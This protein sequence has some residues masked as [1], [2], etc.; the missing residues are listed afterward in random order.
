MNLVE[1]NYKYCS[2]AEL[3]NDFFWGVTNL[4]ASTSI[5]GYYRKYQ[6]ALEFKCFTNA[7]KHYHRH[8]KKATKF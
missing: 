1:Y 7:H 8:R 5:K 4:V 2:M 6:N 3:P